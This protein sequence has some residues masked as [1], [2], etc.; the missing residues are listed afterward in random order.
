M[1]ENLVSIIIPVFNSEQYLHQ[2][3]DS[4]LCQS[5]ES[6][7]IILINDGSTDRSQEICEYYCT[8]Y[9]HILLIDIPNSGV[10]TARNAGIKIA[11]GKYIQFVDSDDTIDRNMV[12]KMVFLAENSELSICGF[13]QVEPG[14][15]LTHIDILSKMPPFL[16]CSVS[17][18][19]GFL[20]SK[21]LLNSPCNKLYNGQIIKEHNLLFDS[22]FDLGEDLIFNLNYLKFVNSISFTNEPLYNNFNRGNISLTR[23]FRLNLFENTSHLY[24]KVIDFMN[25]DN[26]FTME[27]FRII[28]SWYVLSVVGCIKNR[29]S[30]NTRKRDEKPLLFLE[31]IGSNFHLKNA[32]R[33]VKTVCFR[34][35]IILI[36]LKKR[37]FKLLHSILSIYK[38]VKTDGKKKKNSSLPHE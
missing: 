34:D 36:L 15:K 3:I 6:I 29:Y 4:V 25:L 7:E 17:S 33:D 23:K 1:K 12:S 38:R 24:E 30:L 16:S 18:K 5:H 10:S 2:C 21:N 11:S 20:F 22:N 8:I 26:S 35:R 37:M 31:N 14:N 13:S 27:D 28:N 9:H 19:F 32:I